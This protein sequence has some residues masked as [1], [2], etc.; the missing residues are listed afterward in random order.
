MGLMLLW[1]D[2]PDGKT[3]VTI[4]FNGDKPKRVDTIV[5]STQ[6]NPEVTRLD[7]E[8]DLMELVIK[9]ARVGLMKKTLS[10]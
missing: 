9:P 8:R 2:R 4:E 1:V 6:H 5:I 10:N 3:Q 7:M